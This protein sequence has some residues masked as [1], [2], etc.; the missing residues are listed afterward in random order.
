MKYFKAAEKKNAQNFSENWVLSRMKYVLLKCFFLLHSFL[1]NETMLILSMKFWN[2]KQCISKKWFSLWF[3]LRNLLSLELLY[4]RL[5][6]SIST[7]MNQ[8][9]SKEKNITNEHSFIQYYCLLTTKSKLF[10][11]VSW[12]DNVYR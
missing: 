1:W 6:K 12:L 9:S 11:T 8:T 7:K 5:E 10:Q 3:I 4:V 2:L